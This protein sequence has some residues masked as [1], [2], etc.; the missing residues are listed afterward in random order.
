M[1]SLLTMAILGTFATAGQ[2]LMTVAFRQA[3]AGKLAPYNYTSIVWAA[4]F[5][6]VIWN[7]TMPPLS[8][9]GIALIVGSAIAVAV[10]RKDPEGPL[11]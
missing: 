9:V 10:S 11:A 4:V 3:D 1:E 6:Y 5:G 2:L 8:L 7:E